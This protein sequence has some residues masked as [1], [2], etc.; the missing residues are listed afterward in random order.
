MTSTENPYILTLP[1]KGRGDTM[2]RKFTIE[3]AR[4]MTGLTQEK[5]AKELGISVATYISYE[6]YKTFMRMDTAHKLSEVTNIELND[7]I[8][9]PKKYGKTVQMV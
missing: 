7:I 3:Q 1:N 6:H 5:M 8:F 2:P 4:S 9:L